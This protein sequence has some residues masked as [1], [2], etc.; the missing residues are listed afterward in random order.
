KMTPPDNLWRGFVRQSAIP[1]P[2]YRRLMLGGGGR[3]IP[4]RV[5]RTRS[6]INLCRCAAL[7][8]NRV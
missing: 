3:S 7:I 8:P 1:I 5:L 2:P 6:M 4:I